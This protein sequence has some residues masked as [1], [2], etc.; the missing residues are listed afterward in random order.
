[1]PELS[2]RDKRHWSDLARM[3]EIFDRWMS[4]W[5][6]FRTFRFE[7]AFEVDWKPAIDVVDKKDHIL[8]KADI[9]GV[10]KENIDISMTSDTLTLKGKMERNEEEKSESYYRSER[11][12]GTFGRILR[13]P[14][15][16]DTGKVKATLENG[17]LELKLPKMEEKKPSEIKIEVK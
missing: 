17:I 4:E 2:R 6:P 11:V 8:V 16:V 1:M 10:K 7:P 9:P 15:D 12:Y 13:L 5:T 3:D 14:S